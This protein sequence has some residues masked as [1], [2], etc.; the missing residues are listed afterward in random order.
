MTAHNCNYMHKYSLPTYIQRTHVFAYKYYKSMI[1]LHVQPLLK[2]SAIYVKQRH[3][4][5]KIRKLKVKSV[6]VSFRTSAFTLASVGNYFQTIL[7]SY[8]QEPPSDYVLLFLDFNIVTNWGSSPSWQP[9][10]Q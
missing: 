7:P 2:H 8:C 3:L 10:L 9:M 1:C 5:T 6:K 4:V